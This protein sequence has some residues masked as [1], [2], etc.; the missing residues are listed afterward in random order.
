MK[1][2]VPT[3]G[4]VDPAFA[5]VLVTPSKWSALASARLYKW[6]ADNECFSG[7]FDY[8]KFIKWID[9]LRDYRSNC[10]FV[11]VPDAPGSAAETIDMYH[12]WSNQ[13]GDWPLA[14][15]AQDGQEDLPFPNTESWTTLFVGGS[16]RWKTSEACISVIKRAQAMGKR[17]HI[18]RVNWWKRYSYFAS[19]IGSEEFTCDGTRTRFDGKDKTFRTWKQ[20]QERLVLK[21]W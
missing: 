6:A 1:F 7:K 10:L 20:Y 3:S 17:I 14:F 4:D 19:I 16:T 9:G 5:G 2:L 18:G 13:F 11:V 21:I 8:C 15:V 12:R